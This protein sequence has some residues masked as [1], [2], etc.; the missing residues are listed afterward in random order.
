[1]VVLFAIATRALPGATCPDT[2][3]VRALV[4][5]QR[6]RYPAMGI[7]DVLKLLQQATMGSEHWVTTRDDA[8]RWMDSEWNTLSVDTLDALVDTLGAHG[9]F[10]RVYLAP[11]RAAGGR[12]GPLINAFVATG[13]VHGDTAIL[14][15]ALRHLITLTERRELP[16]NSD[17]V[18]AAIRRWRRAGYPALDHTPTYERAY[19][20]H[21]R[22]VALPL[23]QALL[24]EAS[25]ARDTRRPANGPRLQ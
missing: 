15:C 3:A 8:Q 6:V 20:P 12:P 9:K 19:R 16:W 1:L 5:A 18:A 2:S 14:G 10:A 4:N 23:L 24:R 25:P 7:A 17:S 13:R 22:V 21:Y 11:Y